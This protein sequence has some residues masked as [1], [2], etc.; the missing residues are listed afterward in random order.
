MKTIEEFRD[1]VRKERAT[2]CGEAVIECYATMFLS[3][4]YR[5]CYRLKSKLAEKIRYYEE[6]IRNSLEY[7]EREIFFFTKHFKILTNFWNY[8]MD[9]K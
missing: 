2:N 3:P 5:N 7:N 8:L 4:Y 6:H 1:Y 9:E